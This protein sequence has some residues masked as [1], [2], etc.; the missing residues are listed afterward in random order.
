MRLLL[1]RHGQT[2]S[3]IGHH[4]DTAEPG[5]DL[6]DFG[7]AQAQ[8]IPAALAGESIAAIYVSNLVRTQQTAAPL[9]QALGL[10]PLIRPGVREIGAGDLEM[11]NDRPS[12]EAYVGQ[13][14]GWESDLDARMPGAETGREVLG[15]FDEVVAEAFGQVGEGTAVIVSHGAMIRMWVA[16]RSDN[17]DLTYAAEHPLENTAL[18]ALHGTPEEGWTVDLWTHTALGGPELTDTR[19]TGPGGESDEDPSE[20]RE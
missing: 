14:F 16:G 4:L 12:L 17:I 6:T 15:R 5:A 11:A 1:V 7:R 2:S 10:E 8:A 19:H 18:V 9:A 13:V 20:S 3:N